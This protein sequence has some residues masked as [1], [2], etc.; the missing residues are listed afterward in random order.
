ML[1]HSGFYFHILR[2]LF[3]NQIYVVSRYMH[4]A[5]C[6]NEQFFYYVMMGLTC[7]KPHKRHGSLL[8][9]VPLMYVC[10]FKKIR[11]KY[12][13]HLWIATKNTFASSLHARSSS[14]PKKVYIPAEYGD[15][16][17]IWIFSMAAVI[18]LQKF[19]G[20]VTKS[21]FYPFLSKRSEACAFAFWKIKPPKFVESRLY[22]Y[23]RPW[24]ALPVPMNRKFIIPL[25]P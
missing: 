25:P 16:C 23:K 20:L 11:R 12:I 19:C 1:A 18:A 10:L 6:H 17:I 7:H 8:N 5:T 2:A 22:Y 24:T 4:C 15:S 13:T 21:M 9:R 3:I 14:S